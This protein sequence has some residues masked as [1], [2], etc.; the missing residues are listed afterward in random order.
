M[1]KLFPLKIFSFFFEQL[2][3]ERKTPRKDTK[4]HKKVKK[5]L[6]FSEFGRFWSTCGTPLLAQETALKTCVVL[7]KKV[8]GSIRVQN[9]QTKS[10][11]DVCEPPLSGFKKK[12]NF[13]SGW[14][15]F[16]TISK[17][18]IFNR[19]NACINVANFLRLA[20][21]LKFIFLFLKRGGSLV[22][23]DSLGMR[24]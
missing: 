24:S 17:N 4:E 15:K 5:W 23:S 20:I 11:G 2:N 19:K 18:K 22:P 1:L 21:F 3:Y 8:S 14:K 9:F 12:W 10:Q 6:F 7:Q 13:F 16:V